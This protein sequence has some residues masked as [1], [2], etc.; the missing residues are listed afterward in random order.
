MYNIAVVSSVSCWAALAFNNLLSNKARK[1]TSRSR[2]DEYATENQF[3]QRV[4]AVIPSP[5]P[6]TSFRQC[7]SDGIPVYVCSSVIFEPI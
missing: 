4:V 6:N 5:T 1:G 2:K 3:S 7:S